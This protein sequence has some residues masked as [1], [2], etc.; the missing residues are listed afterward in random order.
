MNKLLLLVQ[1][2]INY[3]TVELIISKV[4]YNSYLNQSIVSDIDCF[5]EYGLS[6][7]G[8]SRS[9]NSIALTA[10]VVDNLH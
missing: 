5:Y 2:S 10:Y 6:K 9:V 7:V 1:R 3:I 4:L 8:Q